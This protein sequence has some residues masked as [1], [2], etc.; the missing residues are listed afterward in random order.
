MLVETIRWREGKVELIDQRI[1]PHKFKYVEC[2]TSKDIFDAIRVMKVR[3]APAIGIA[4]AFG[5][6][7]GI[8]S[9]KAKD[10]KSFRKEV[11]KIIKYLSGSRPTANNLFWAMNKMDEVVEVNQKKDIETI[12]KKMLKKARMILKE[13]ISKCR[14]IGK[15]GEKLFKKGSRV[16]THCNA[17]GLATGGYGTALGVIFA[18]KNKLKKVYV[19]ETRPRLQGARLTLWELEKNNIPCVLICD[20]MA[21][22]LMRRGE[23]DTVIVGADRIAA[24]GDTANKI[25]TYSVA[26]LADYHNIP[27]YVAAPFSTFDLSIKS[28]KE[29]TIEQREDREVKEICRNCITTKNAKVLNFAFDVTPAKLITGIITEKGVI[30]KPNRAKIDQLVKK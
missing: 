7:L 4:G 29:I 11:F 5:V 22:D 25:G 28:G 21:G 8:K 17:G 14:V 23:I 9:S 10:F 20:N 15:N 24:N 16:L 6:Y 18:A 19:D 27:L 2:C 13:D 26:V 1:L 30:K 3:G 12:K